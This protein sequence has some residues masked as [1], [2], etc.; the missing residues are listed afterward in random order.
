MILILKRTKLIWIKKQKCGVNTY[1]R[2]QKKVGQFF[3]ANVSR[4]TLSM[5]I[6][7]IFI[8]LS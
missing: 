4:F 3:F 7:E 8:Y 5:V 2:G 1:S 6:F